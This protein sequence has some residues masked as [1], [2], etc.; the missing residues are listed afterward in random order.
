MG[1]FSYFIKGGETFI[2]ICLSIAVRLFWTFR[3]NCLL[4]MYLLLPSEWCICD[5]YHS[6]WIVNCL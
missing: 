3:P 1:N 2:T 4:F 5:S 6:Q